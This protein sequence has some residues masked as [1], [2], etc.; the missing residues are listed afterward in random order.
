M[1]TKGIFHAYGLFWKKE[2]V[3][4]SPGSGKRT[5]MLLGR[6]GKT[7]PRLRIANFRFQQGIYILYGDYGPYY[8]GLTRDQGLGKRLKD[9][10]FDAHAKKWDRFSWFSFGRV[11]GKRDANGLRC[12]A[13]LPTKQALD[14][15]SAIGDIEAILIRAMALQNLSKMKFA[16]AE[17]WEQV[18]KTEIEHYWNKVRR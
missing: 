1:S 18:R 16:Q 13:E 9:H 12:F 14:T 11:L 8:A 10:V 15:E 3:D 17:R 6:R 5:F 2:E 4:W 7:R